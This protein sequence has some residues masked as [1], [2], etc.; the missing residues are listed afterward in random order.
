MRRLPLL[1]TSMMC[2]SLAVA[3]GQN[4]YGNNPTAGGNFVPGRA[5][6]FLTGEPKLSLHPGR[7]ALDRPGPSY[8]T[9]RVPKVQVA[10]RASNSGTRRTRPDRYPW[11]LDIVTTIF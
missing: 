9:N 7:S 10:L 11:K 2:G 5:N 4:R 3:S 1:L 6:S 8:A